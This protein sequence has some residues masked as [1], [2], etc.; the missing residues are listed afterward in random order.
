M[1]RN[2][3]GQFAKSGLKRFM[4]NSVI[5]F[6]LLGLIVLVAVIYQRTNPVIVT[7]EVKVTVD[8][9]SEMFAQKIDSLEKSVVE[10]VRKC[11]QSSYNES[12][13][14]VTFDP[15]N[16]QYHA[17]QTQDKHSIVDKGEFSYG[18]LQFKK[19]TVI[20]YYKSLYGKV[21]TLPVITFPY[22]DL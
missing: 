20:Y 17:I 8:T 13:G 11:E 6:G 15:T 1:E 21:I 3:N 18:T 14:L 9:S 7:N 2:S 19:T 10:A 16:S 5:G 22:K 12:D 4:R